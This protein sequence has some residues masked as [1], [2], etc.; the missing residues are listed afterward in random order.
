MKNMGLCAAVAALF[1]C[2]ST[3]AF[4][5]TVETDCTKPHQPVDRMVCNNAALRALDARTNAYYSILLEAKP[6]ADT[7]AYHDFRDG[8]QAEQQKWQHDTRDACGAQLSCLTQ[9]YQNRIDALRDSALARLSLVVTAAPAQSQPAAPSID[10]KNAIYHV[11]D[12]DVT[13]L[14]GQHAQPAADDSSAQ[15][16]TH[17]VEPP[18]HAAGKLGGR[19]VVAVFL[20]EEGGGS[21][22]FYYV[23]LAFNDGRGTTFKIGDRIQPISIAIN[24]DDLVVSYLDRKAD[25]PMAVPPTVPRERHFAYMNGQIL[26]RPQAAAAQ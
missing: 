18:A 21:G 6:A 15:D 13:L 7:K 4:A 3:I 24:G 1:A 9:A 16:V 17:I 19:N 20:S 25:E 22:T 12:K 8:L 2:A 5:Q 11:G 14:E 26:E 23:A 10:Y